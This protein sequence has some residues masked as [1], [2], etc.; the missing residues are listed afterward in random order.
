MNKKVYVFG[1]LIVA[2]VFALAFTAY[3][4]LPKAA[5][6]SQ[7]GLSILK[8][9]K[10]TDEFIEQLK[11]YR[12]KLTFDSVEGAEYLLNFMLEKGNTDESLAY[13]EKFADK[14]VNDN[15]HINASRLFHLTGQIDNAKKSLRDSD[16]EVSYIK[17]QRIMHFSSSLSFKS[18]SSFSISFNS[19]W[20]TS[21]TFSPVF[22]E[23]S[24]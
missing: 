23:H 5:L 3:Q 1:S 4:F 17:I 19:V 24:R 11:E 16:H 10:S 13:Y 22:D 14:I 6:Y 2:G 21:A 8:E 18:P 15:T 7:A 12:P 9:G 20:N